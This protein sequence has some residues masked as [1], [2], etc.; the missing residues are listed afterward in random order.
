VLKVGKETIDR[1][2]KLEE[3]CENFLV[4]HPATW[5]YDKKTQK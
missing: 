4:K 3:G 5:I 1:E 2:N